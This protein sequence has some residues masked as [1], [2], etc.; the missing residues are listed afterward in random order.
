MKDVIALENCDH[1]GQNESSNSIYGLAHRGDAL[2]MPSVTRR[3]ALAIIVHSI[4]LYQFLCTL[5]SSFSRKSLHNRH[6]KAVKIT[7]HLEP[8]NVRIM[9]AAPSGVFPVSCPP[10]YQLPMSVSLPFWLSMA[11]FGPTFETSLRKAPK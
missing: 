6:Q 11:A 1:M 5:A 8:V 9:F 3:E 10:R 4:G 2:Y 7:T